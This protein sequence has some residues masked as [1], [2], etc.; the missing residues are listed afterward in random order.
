MV[1]KPLKISATVLT[2]S[3]LNTSIKNVPSLLTKVKLKPDTWDMKAEKGDGGRW[4][5]GEF[6]VIADKRRG[7]N[8]QKQILLENAV[9]KSSSVCANQNIK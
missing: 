5:Q 4:E 6:K 1:A 2:V 7:E 8:Q 9:I 3:G